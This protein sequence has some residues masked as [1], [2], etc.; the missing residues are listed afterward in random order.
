MLGLTHMYVVDIELPTTQGGRSDIVRVRV[1]VNLFLLKH[2]LHER[3]MYFEIYHDVATANR[4]K[5]AVASEYLSSRFLEGSTL[6]SKRPR[7]SAF[8][9]RT[10]SSILAYAVTGKFKG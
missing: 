7:L 8:R 2:R 3:Y 1:A 5:Q 6:S 9:F 4:Y 10:M